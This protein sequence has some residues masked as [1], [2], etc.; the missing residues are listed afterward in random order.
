MHNK[1]ILE[2]PD[3]SNEFLTQFSVQKLLLGGLILSKVLIK[4][5]F[6]ISNLSSSQRLII[7]IDIIIQSKLGD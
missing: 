3:K 4:H 5:K 6:T 1:L 2:N 7:P